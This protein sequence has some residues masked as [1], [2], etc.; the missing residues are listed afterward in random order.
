MEFDWRPNGDIWIEDAPMDEINN[1]A[2]GLTDL[3]EEIFANE[4]VTAAAL[5]DLNARIKELEE[6]LKNAGL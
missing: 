6:R 4:E 1:I 5:N 2:K 3:T